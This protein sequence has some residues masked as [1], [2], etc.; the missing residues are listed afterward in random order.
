[1]QAHP[2]S[3]NSGGNR[4]PGQISRQY[5]TTSRSGRRFSA[6]NSDKRLTESTPLLLGEEESGLSLSILICRYPEK[7]RLCS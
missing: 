4:K 6:I 2:S 7:A 1:M 5:K 3:S